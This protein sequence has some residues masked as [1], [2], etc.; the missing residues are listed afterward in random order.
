[1]NKLVEPTSWD[2]GDAAVARIKVARDGLHGED[3][4]S[5][6]KRA[7]HHLAHQMRGLEFHPGEVPIHLIAMGC[8]EAFS[9]N[10]NGDG[11]TEKC[12]RQY[13]PSFV[14]HARVFREH[15]N[16]DRARSY[17]VVKSSH[18]NEEMR[19]VELI[20]ALNG[21]KEAARRNGGLVADR[22]LDKLD[23]NREI[24]VSMATRVPFD[25]CSWCHN[26]AATR[27]E[28]CTSKNCGGGGLRDN[29]TAV[30]KCGHVLHADNPHCKFF[31]ISHVDRGADPTAAVTGRLEKAAS[32]MLNNRVVTGAALAELYA[33]GVPSWL[34]D[35]EGHSGPLCK[36]AAALADLEREDVP[37]MTSCGPLP[38]LPPNVKLAEALKALADERVV[39]SLADYLELAS[40]GDRAKAAAVANLSRPALPGVFDRLAEG[41]EDALVNSC[42]GLH[43]RPG[44][45][46]R[47]WAQKVAFHRTLSPRILLRRV[48]EAALAGPDSGRFS[49]SAGS[50]ECSPAAA[51]VARLYGGYV[52][53]ALQLVESSYK[54]NRLT[55]LAVLA[56]NHF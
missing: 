29:I 38:A 37:E 14:K 51:A 43:C 4:R 3:L 23:G 47:L 42:P 25:V 12:L 31:D 9:S 5:F 53:N 55:R 21:T 22:E 19:R 39:L 17:G 30:L 49:K 7:S 54:E 13:H 16:T 34:E 56:Q 6:V 27:K 1:M 40:A 48:H 35:A 10:R 8:T 45:A 33:P 15:Q 41:D 18:Y 46:A 26:K 2:L 36:L 44:V 11:F 32:V 52:V 24:Q 50:T 28:Y 20:C